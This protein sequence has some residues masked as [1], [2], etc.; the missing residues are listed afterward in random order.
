MDYKA[1][2]QAFGWYRVFLCALLFGG[3]G[4]AMMSHGQVLLGVFTAFGLSLSVFLLFCID[5][6]SDQRLRQE[7][8]R[9]FSDTDM[10]HLTTLL[11]K[12]ANTEL[13]QHV[14]YT[15]LDEFNNR[16]WIALGYQPDSYYAGLDETALQH[17]IDSEVYIDLD[18]WEQR[19]RSK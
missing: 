13:D 2:F 1:A 8:A 11:K 18:K 19:E 4:L 5:W 17:L 16:V 9:T 14:G 15:F 6:R 7:R 10:H 12:Y 3:L